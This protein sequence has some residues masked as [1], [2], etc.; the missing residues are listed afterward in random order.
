M[1][2]Q[3]AVSPTPRSSDKCGEAL[4]LPIRR[5]KQ[6]NKKRR[7]TTDQIW[8]WAFVFFYSRETETETLPAA[9]SVGYCARV[10]QNRRV[11]FRLPKTGSRFPVEPSKI[12]VGA[13]LWLSYFQERLVS[14]NIYVFVVFILHRRYFH[15]STWRR[16]RQYAQCPSR[17]LILERGQV[18]HTNHVATDCCDTERKP[19]TRLVAS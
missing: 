17:F 6:T 18:P 13:Q 5:I 9:F 2:R 15:P 7:L 4:F 3:S 10:A 19:K 8:S 11:G 12:G 1:S 14:S 16:V